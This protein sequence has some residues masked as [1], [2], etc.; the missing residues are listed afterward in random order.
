MEM[1]TEVYVVVM[2]LDYVMVMVLDYVV[3]MVSDYVVEEE[4][5]GTALNHILDYFSLCLCLFCPTQDFLHSNHH[6]P[7]QEGCV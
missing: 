3:V 4:A 6:H 1:R 5:D 2:V 7:S